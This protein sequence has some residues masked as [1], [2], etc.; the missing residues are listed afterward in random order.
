LC[1]TVP[2]LPV[3]VAA[4][5][6]SAAEGRGERGEGRGVRYATS[7]AY[8]SRCACVARRG[9]GRAA[10]VGGDQRECHAR[11][12]RSPQQGPGAGAGG[13]QA[14][15]GRGRAKVC[16]RLSRATCTLVRTERQ[17]ADPRM[18]IRARGAQEVR[19]GCDT[20]QY[21]ARSIGHLAQVRRSLLAYWV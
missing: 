2:P 20:E 8:H 7:L 16:R 18:P 19:A 3:A 12:G 21:L 5:V 9:D 17:A 10:G 14:L 15:C 6:R 13:A 11:Q 4:A 1:A